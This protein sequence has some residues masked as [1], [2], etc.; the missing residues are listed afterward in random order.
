MSTLFNR[1]GGARVATALP[2]LPAAAMTYI[3]RQQ[4]GELLEVDRS[5]PLPRM[6]GVKVRGSRRDTTTARLIQ[7][8]K[9]E[10]R[11]DLEVIGD[12]YRATRGLSLFK[13]ADGGPIEP[14][15]DGCAECYRIKAEIDTSRPEDVWVKRQIR[16]CQSCGSGWSIGIPTA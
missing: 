16:E 1:M 9:G 13:P 15:W 11:K 6:E 4:A 2:R 7:L 10:A 12:A 5:Q 8:Q 14:R 3:E